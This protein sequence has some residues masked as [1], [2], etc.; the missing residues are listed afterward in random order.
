[1]LTLYVWVVCIQFVDL[2]GPNAVSSCGMVMN[3]LFIVKLQK[4]FLLADVLLSTVSV[5]PQ[6]SDPSFKIYYF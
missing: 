1:M 2:I 4:L 3:L 6:L 5:G